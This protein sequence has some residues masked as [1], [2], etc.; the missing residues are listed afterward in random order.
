[1]SKTAGRAQ[2]CLKRRPA[3]AVAAGGG[4]AGLAVAVSTGDRIAVLVALIGFV[5]AV[6]SFVVQQ[7]GVRGLVTQFIG[8]RPATSGADAGS[9]Q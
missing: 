6:V 5:P 3:E 8:A 1:M 7:G 4:V 9:G 2:A